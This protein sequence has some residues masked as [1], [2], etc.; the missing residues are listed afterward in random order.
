M[1]DAGD[2][3]RRV[4]YAALEDDYLLSLAIEDYSS[5]RTIVRFLRK[6]KHKCPAGLTPEVIKKL[7]APLIQ[8]QGFAPAFQIADEFADDTAFY[9]SL[10]T[11][12]NDIYIERR[13]AD[14]RNYYSIFGFYAKDDKVRAA[15]NLAHACR[16][17][18]AN[19]SVFQQGALRQG[20]LGGIAQRLKKCMP[21]PPDMLENFRN[22]PLPSLP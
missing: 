1:L 8:Q 19:L 17:D 3:A 11:V 10:L 14:P 16:H 15:R 7:F 20:E 9:R 5:P 13:T 18:A 4:F 12:Y 2:Q 22:W 21:A 6:V